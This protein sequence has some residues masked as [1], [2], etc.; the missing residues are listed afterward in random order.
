MKSIGVV[1][2][3]ALRSGEHALLQFQASERQMTFAKGVRMPIDIL[4][5]YD[6]WEDIA[7]CAS[8]RQDHAN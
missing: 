8:A 2:G 5:R 6:H 7:D 3:R 4:E 1:L